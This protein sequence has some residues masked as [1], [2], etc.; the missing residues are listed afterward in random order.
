MNIKKSITE[1]VGN[2][3]LVEL[4]NYENLHNLNATLIGKLEYL[5]PTG[6]VKDRAA[7]SMI[8]KGEAEG[9][10]AGRYYRREYQWKYRNFSG[11]ICGGQRI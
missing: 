7:L 9:I 8:E 2:T 5:N 11:G 10:K 1:L 3:P 4:T 6:S